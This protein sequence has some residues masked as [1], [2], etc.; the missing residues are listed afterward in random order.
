MGT[1]PA[2]QSILNGTFVPPEGT[3]PYAV[4]LLEL[5]A[6]PQAIRD[7]PP[8]D[9]SLNVKQFRKSWSQTKEATSSGG[10]LHF[11]HFK[12]S[13]MNEELAEFEAIMANIPYQTGL[14][15]ERWTDSTNVMLEKKEADYRVHRLRTIL[16]MAADFN[17][18]NKRTGRDFMR[19][20]E[21]HRTIARE[22]YGSR[23]NHASI[24]HCVNKVLTFDLLRQKRQP[25]GHMATDAVSCY[26]RIAHSVA[27]LCMQ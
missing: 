27:S 14:L 24:D 17:H 15:V 2:A 11:G 3:D 12:A 25:G 23:R 8:V 13:V 16:L 20:A 1:G 19:N 18:N 21:K 9:V 6:M 26:D 22:Q 5:L 4:K 7:A 10:P